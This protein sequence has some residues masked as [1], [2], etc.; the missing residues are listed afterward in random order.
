VIEKSQGN[1]GETIFWGEKERKSIR[2]K[3][4]TPII[5]RL[6]K[7]DYKFKTRLGYIGRPCLRKTN[8]RGNS[9]AK[10]P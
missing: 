5:R 6:R 1:P 2:N 10:K 4:V 7:E 3:E 8:K 9:T